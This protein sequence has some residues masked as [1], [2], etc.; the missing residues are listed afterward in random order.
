MIGGIETVSVDC[1]ASEATAPSPAAPPSASAM[2]RRA[3]RRAD[4]STPSRARAT[5]RSLKE[6]LKVAL[7]KIVKSVK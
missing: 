3:R 6:W 5:L 4:R 1:A 2:D 7:G